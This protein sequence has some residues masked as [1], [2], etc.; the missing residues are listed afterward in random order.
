MTLGT[1]EKSKEL[2]I[3]KN[4]VRGVWSSGIGMKDQ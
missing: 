1:K 4:E 3:R 2:G